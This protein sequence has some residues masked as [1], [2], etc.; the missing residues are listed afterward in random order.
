MS[1]AIRIPP[2]LRR[3]CEGAE[4]I[5]VQPGTIAG[6]VNQLHSRFHGVRDRLMDERGQLRGSVLVF[7][8]EED[9]RF[10]QNEETPIQAGDEV[11]IIPAFAGG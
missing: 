7:V 6:A 4:V 11:S 3:F 1:V 8:N 5:R 9:V 2:T 10:L